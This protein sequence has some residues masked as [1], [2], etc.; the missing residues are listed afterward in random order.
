MSANHRKMF[1]AVVE[2]DPNLEG[3]PQ[4]FMILRYAHIQIG[5]PACGSRITTSEQSDNLN[6]ADKERLHALSLG[7]CKVRSISF[8]FLKVGM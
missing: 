7:L 5:Q 6:G 1:E 8:Q 4:P 3:R 2:Q